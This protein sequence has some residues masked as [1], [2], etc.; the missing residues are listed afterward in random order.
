[1]SKT[2]VFGMNAAS[3]PVIMTQTVFPVE[4]VKASPI[5][6]VQNQYVPKFSSQRKVLGMGKENRKTCKQCGKKLEE[7]RCPS[8]NHI[9]ILV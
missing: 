8:K 1:M 6:R 3:Y 2:R 5:E 9:E 4:T 7:G